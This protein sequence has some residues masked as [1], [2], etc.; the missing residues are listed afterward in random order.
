MSF[1]FRDPGTKYVR[2]TITDAQSRSASLEHDVIVSPSNALPVPAFTYSPSNPV[3]DLRSPLMR[4]PPR[5]RHHLVPTV[6]RTM[7]TARC[8]ERVSE[9]HSPSGTREPSTSG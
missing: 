5:A 8:S 4:R 1:T 2:L 6:G 3:P 9:C 7:P